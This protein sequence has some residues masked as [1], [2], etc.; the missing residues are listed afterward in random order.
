MP[1]EKNRITIIGT[2]LMGGSLGLALKAAGLQDVEIVGHDRE[3]ANANRAQS[4]GAIDRAEHNLPRAVAGAGV[5]VIAT[6]ALA[7]R[8]VLV[9]IAPEVDE[10]VIVTDTASTKAQIMRWAQE[11]LPEGVSFV[12]GHPMA[13]KETHGVE[14]ADGQMFRGRAYCICPSLSASESAV[15]TVLGLAK[16]VG[17]EPLFVDPEE[18]DQLAAAVSHL[19]LMMSAAIFNLLRS[20]PSWPD[21]APMASSGFRDVTRLA[22]GDPTMSHDIWV[23]NREAVIHWLA[24]LE[25]ELQRFRNLLQDADDKALLEIFTRVQMERDAFLARPPRRQAPALDTRPEAQRALLDMIVG[26]MVA[27]RMRKIQ[28]LAESEGKPQPGEGAAASRRPALAQRVA[29]DIRRDLERLED[30]RAAKETRD[31]GPQGKTED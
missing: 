14:H 9:Q 26:G 7:V 15:R 27:E 30:K 23:T 16:A 31:A 24:R 10:G 1:K 12:G 25:A 20:S 17:A 3:R 8:E 5:V 19:P 13:G 18:H 2:G 4:I 6:P 28:K 11:L 21:M 22:S 29:E